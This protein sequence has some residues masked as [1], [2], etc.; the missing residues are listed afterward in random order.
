MSFASTK[1]H[2]TNYFK[3]LVNA[4]QTRDE[5]RM[6]YCL[7]IYLGDSWQIAQRR[8]DWRWNKIARVHGYSDFDN[9]L[10]FFGK[11]VIK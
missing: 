2:E 5:R 9:L 8:R 11:G 6:K 7:C 3:H 10:K 1:E 4:H